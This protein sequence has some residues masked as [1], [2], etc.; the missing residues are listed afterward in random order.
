MGTD[1]LTIGGTLNGFWE[2]Y[3]YGSVTIDNLEAAE[4]NVVEAAFIDGIE[5]NTNSAGIRRAACRYATVVA[6]VKLNISPARPLN[7]A[8]VSAGSAFIGYGLAHY[9]LDHYLHYAL[10]VSGPPFAD[11][12]SSCD[13]ALRK[14]GLSR[15]SGKTNTYAVGVQNAVEFIDPAYEPT[16]SSICSWSEL[17]KST[18]YDYI[19]A[20]DSILSKDAQLSYAIPVNF[21][22]GGQDKVGSAM[23]QGQWYES[24]IK[25][26]VADSCVADA[27]HQLPD[28]EDG[29]FAVAEALIKMN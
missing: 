12:P 3:K 11:L 16:Y 21:M 2:Q 4:H 5:M 1:I 29:A 23:T 20:P 9:G 15:C 14:P 13:G 22:W 24:S 8:G 26:T 27:P 25:S 19:F 7:A 18:K 17:N 6:W 28:V 10:L